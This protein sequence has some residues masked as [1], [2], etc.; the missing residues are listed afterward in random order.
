MQAAAAGA[1]VGAESGAES[2]G[3]ALSAHGRRVQRRSIQR[4]V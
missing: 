4:R 3:A 2:G 1:A